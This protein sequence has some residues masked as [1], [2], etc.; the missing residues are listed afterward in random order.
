MPL[1]LVIQGWSDE[2]VED[3]NDIRRSTKKAHHDGHLH[4]HEELF[5]QLGVDQFNIVGSRSKQFIGNETFPARCKHSREQ[6]VLEHEPQHA[7]QQRSSQYTEQSTPQY[8]Q[9]VPEGHLRLIIVTHPQT[10]LALLVLGSCLLFLGGF[11]D[12][13]GQAVETVT[14]AFHA[15]AKSF[16]QLRN[17]LTA[18]KQQDNQSDYYNLRCT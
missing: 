5:C 2:L 6:L 4:M 15:L 9:V 11:V 17:L 7:E 1:L 18:E 12:V 14:I 13:L 3:E 10:C 16:H 8:F